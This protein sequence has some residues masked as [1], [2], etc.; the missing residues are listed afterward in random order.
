[1]KI[2]LAEYAVGTGEEALLAE[3]RAMLFTLKASF[4]RIGHEIVYPSGVSDFDGWVEK[5]AGDCDAALVIAPDEFIFELT[6]I[7]ESRTFNLGCPPHAARKCAD[8]LLT[9]KILEDAGI[10]VPRT[11]SIEDFSSVG[12]RNAEL[13]MQENR[14]YVIKPRFGCAAEDT[15]LINISTPLRIPEGKEFIATEFLDGEHISV[16]MISPAGVSCSLCAASPPLPLTINKQFIRI[17]SKISYEGGL[18]PYP[19]PESVKRHVFAIAE[20]VVRILGCEGYVGIDIVLGEEGEPY[21]VDVNPRPTT[22]IVGVAKVINYEI[23]DL[24][25]R[26]KLGGV[27]PSDLE[28][29]GSFS[30]DKKDLKN[31]VKF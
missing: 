15:F 11:L 24:I 3:G 20:E 17:N 16:S 22:S 25:L 7:V 12:L 27:L 29:E 28:V 1:M 6:K 13:R 2:M 4:E 23:A 5:N 8:K 14:Y 19:V 10:P 18:V 21:V 9:T 31:I 30:F 26:A